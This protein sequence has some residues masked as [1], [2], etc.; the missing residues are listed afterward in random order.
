[1]DRCGGSGIFLARAGD[2]N[3][4]SILETVTATAASCV[5]AQRYL[6]AARD[7]D[8][9]ILLLDGEPLGAVL[10]VPARGD[11]RGNFHAGAVRSGPS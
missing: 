10:R 4:R 8:K 2:P 5:M 11:A 6:P 9:R 3:L 1:M 7:G